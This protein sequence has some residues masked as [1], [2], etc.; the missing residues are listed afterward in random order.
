MKYNLFV[1]L[2]LVCAFTVARTKESYIS[3]SL[4]EKTVNIAVTPE[5]TTDQYMHKTDFGFDL[6]GGDAKHNED[7]LRIRN[8]T[9][10]NKQKA[11]ESLESAFKKRINDYD[12]VNKIIFHYIKEQ[13]K[14]TDGS[15]FDAKNYNLYKL[16]VTV[17][18]EQW[19]N[20]TLKEADMMIGNI[21]SANT[22]NRADYNYKESSRTADYLANQIMNK[23]R[24]RAQ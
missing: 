3:V 5:I 17:Y 15:A 2:A 20:V 19:G 10:V 16:K 24:Q 11:Q 4:S 9:D 6:Y 7:F 14:Y 22:Q 8:V 12:K 18:S 13:E 21:Y 23:C 1:V